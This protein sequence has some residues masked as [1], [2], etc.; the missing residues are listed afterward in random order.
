M[1]QLYFSLLFIVAFLSTTFAQTKE[2]TLEDI[3]QGTF[4]TEGLEALHS[5]NNGKQYSVLNFNHADRNF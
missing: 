3:Y 1:R 4:R 5:I 2:I